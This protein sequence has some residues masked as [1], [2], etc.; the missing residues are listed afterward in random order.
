MKTLFTFL[1]LT[2]L[3]SA[4][5]LCRAQQTA[6]NQSLIQPPTPYYIMGEDANSRRWEQ[7]Y[8]EKGPNGQSVA[9]NHQVVE[10]ASG[11]NYQDTNGN[12]QSSEELI[13]PYAQG[14]VAR[15]GQYQVIFANNLNSAGSID[16]QTADGKRLRSNIVGL[17]YHDTASDNAVMIGHL[18]DSQGEL[19]A[20]NQVLYPNA[21]AGVKADVRYSY[22]K[23]GFEQDIILRENLPSPESFGMNPDTTEIEVVTEFL[24]PPEA[25][26]RQRGNNLG[27][28]QDVS[29]GGMSIGRGKAFDLDE[30]G[31]TG[32]EALVRK[33]YTT[34]QGRTF[35][36]EK[37][38]VQDI[39][40]A[41]QNLPAYA[42]VSLGKSISKTAAIEFPKAPLLA[43][44]PNPMKLAAIT[45]SSKGLVLDYVALGSSVTNFTFQGD[46]TYFVSSD[47]NLS[48]VTTIEGGTVIKY[49]TNNACALNILG[50]VNCQ[51]GPYRPAIFTS[52]SDNSVGASVSGLYV[53]PCTGNLTLILNNTSGNYIYVWVYDALDNTIINRRTARSALFSS[54]LGRGR[55][56]ALFSRR[57]Q[58]PQARRHHRVIDRC[59]HANR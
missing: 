25:T 41:L 55:S 6:T 37:V 26:V 32:L 7:T 28:D 53:P 10:L 42:S 15:H 9:K 21:F 51:T 11:L 24:D 8:Y 31:N 45:P 46:T 38:R 49:Y 57:Q 35:L 30:P 39:Q 33:E 2:L 27:E 18:Q 59:G 12:W 1:I 19:I 52:S 5:G 58:L 40:G 48:G 36:M 29:W 43:A 16:L 13:E 17:M 14:A 34:I 3:L 23:G 54:F 4:A 50:T 47:V 44:V 22:R 56:H 20:A